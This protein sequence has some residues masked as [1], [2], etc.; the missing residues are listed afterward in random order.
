MAIDFFYQIQLGS[1]YVTS[2]EADG[3]TPAIADVDG[4]DAFEIDDGSDPVTVQEI[5]ALSGTVYQQVAVPIVDAPIT[6][7]FPLLDADTV[8]DISDVIRAFVASPT[9][10]TAAF[11]GTVRNFTGTAKPRWDPKPVSY[12]GQY[13][14]GKLKNVVVRLYVTLS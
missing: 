13:Q 9:P 11:T 7:T 10:F 6:I 12:S 8:D 14:N 3:G 2:T 4:L 1:V 5:R